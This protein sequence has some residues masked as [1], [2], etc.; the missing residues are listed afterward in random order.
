MTTTEVRTRRDRGRARHGLPTAPR[1][2]ARARGVPR[3]PVPCRGRPLLGRLHR[4]RRLLRAL[5]L[6]RHAGAA[7]I[8]PPRAAIGE[9]DGDTRRRDGRTASAASTPAGTGACCPASFVALVV[10]AV[11]YSAIASQAELAGAVGAFKA[12]F[13]Y[14]ANWYFIHQSSDYFAAAVNANP[15]Q[16]FWSLAVE[17]QF[18]FVWPI[19]LT[20]LFLAT[21]GLPRHAAP[22]PPGRGR[23]RDRGVRGVGAAPRVDQRQPR[24]LRDR[25]PGLPAPRRGAA[26]AEPGR[27]PTPARVP[28]HVVRRSRRRSSRSW[29]CPRRSLDMNPIRRGIATTIATLVLIVGLECLACGPL[30]RLFSSR[31][32]GLSRSDLL[33]DVPVA[34]AGH[35]RRVRAD[36]PRH[37][38]GVDVRDL[39]VRRDRTRV[40]QLSAPRDADPPA[41]APGPH[42][43]G[44]D[45][46]RRRGQHRG[47]A[48][49]HPEHHR[50]VRLER[51]LGR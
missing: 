9:R 4:R 19:L 27:A 47:R 18:Y 22:C 12:T 8:L 2:H 34:L 41:A 28:C 45:R 7:A 43:P 16:Q 48:R 39:G 32:G 44:G 24:V 13:L 46:R 40:A 50:S 29:C 38:P 21:R 35:H 6:P 49:D 42:Q 25:C 33:R 36:G 20:A 17:E 30:N 15:V 5:R 26:R 31:A 11:V 14:V 51:P 10:T 23:R 1:R 37:Q 3:R